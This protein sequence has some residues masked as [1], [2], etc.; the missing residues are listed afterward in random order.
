MKLPEPSSSAEDL[1]LRSS[2]G[3]VSGGSN[4]AVTLL[5]PTTLAPIV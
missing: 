2:Q 1:D 5:M 4:A 3:A